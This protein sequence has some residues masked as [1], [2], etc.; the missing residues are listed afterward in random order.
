M[1]R[2][3]LFLLSFRNTSLLPTSNQDRSHSH[4]PSPC[5]MAPQS[6]RNSPWQALV[7][8]GERGEW[9][10]RGT[11]EE[12]KELRSAIRPSSLGRAA[13]CPTPPWLTPRACF[14]ICKWHRLLKSPWCSAHRRTVPASSGH[15]LLTLRALSPLPAV[16]SPGFLTANSSLDPRYPQPST[17][18]PTP[19]TLFVPQATR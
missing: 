11:G 1:I 8:Q 6:S 12:Q 16:S 7:S 18:L 5:T 19:Y 13:P 9:E 14:L 17:A 3:P 2:G 15:P 10:L 4:L